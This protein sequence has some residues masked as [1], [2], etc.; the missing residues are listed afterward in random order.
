M[1]LKLVMQ[2]FGASGPVALEFKEFRVP[3][4]FLGGVPAFILSFR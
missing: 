2:P 3:A 4:T 1:K